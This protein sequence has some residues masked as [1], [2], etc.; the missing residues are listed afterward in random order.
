VTY[1]LDAHTF[2]WWSRDNPEL[3]KKAEALITNPESSLVLSIA[4]AW[5][6]SLKCSLGKLPD[7]EPLMQSSALLKFLE[8]RAI[9]LLPIT[10]EDI[11]ISVNLPKHHKDPFDR[12]IIAQ[13]QRF[14]MTIITKDD[15]FKDYDVTIVW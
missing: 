10:P 8:E 3:S 13:A 4:S 11:T 1:L 12:L 2:L 6:L 9:Q 14:E 15:A 5:E 7:Y